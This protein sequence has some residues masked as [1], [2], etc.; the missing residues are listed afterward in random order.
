MACYTSKCGQDC[1][2]G[3]SGVTNM[4]GQPGSLPTATD[5]P[6]GEVETL[7]CASGTTMGTCTWRGWRG[8]GLPCSGGCNSGETLVAQ[9]T[10]HHVTVNGKLQDQTCNGG[11]QSYCCDGFKGPPSQSVNT[12]S[13]DIS[14]DDVVGDVVSVIR[15][16][17]TEAIA[18]AGMQKIF[19]F[20][21]LFIK[22]L[23]PSCS[24]ICN[25]R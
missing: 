7:C 15:A 3:Y 2:S 24:L 10:N 4:N 21:A 17:V 16:T 9:N 18:N 20:Q 23:L 11:L 5:C 25:K 1:L 6:S 22:F 13:L 12:N 14:Q 8:Q 19:L